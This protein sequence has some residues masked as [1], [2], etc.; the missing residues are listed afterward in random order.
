MDRGRFDTLA[1]VI[2]AQQSRRTTITTLL[3]ALVLRHAP[4]AA[5]RKSQHRRTAPVTAQVA[6]ACYPGT[7]CTPGKGNNASRCDFSHSTVFR[8]R[9]ARG[10]NL[11][12]SNFF[13]ADLRGADF[14]GANLSGGCFVGA[15]LTGA[16][17]GSSVNLHK[18][19]FCNT[20]MPDGTRDDS[21]CEGETPCCHLLL[22]DCPDGHVDCYADDAN[23]NPVLVGSIGPIGFCYQFPRCCPCDHSNDFDYWREQCAKH[24]GD[25]CDDGCNPVANAVLA[26]D[27]FDPNITD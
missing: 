10:S 13:G 7:R 1:R 6:A 3:S 14:R 18:A 20:V 17:L 22:Q 12:D 21:G 4:A 25:D 19:V 16:K 27:C 8:N 11:S 2:S 5:K 15:D 26:G 24:F 23:G 9:D